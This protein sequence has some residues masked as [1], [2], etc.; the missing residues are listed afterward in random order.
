MKKTNQNKILEKKK[1]P[2][3]RFITLQRDKVFPSL[4]MHF[5]IC[6]AATFDEICHKYNAHQKK[7]FPGIVFQK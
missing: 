5:L 1:H 2:A 6:S 3:T 4:K 7:N